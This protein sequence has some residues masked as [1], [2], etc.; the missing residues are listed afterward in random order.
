MFGLY[1]SQKTSVQICAICGRILIRFDQEV[2]PQKTGFGSQAR[3]FYPADGADS[4]RWPQITCL[5]CVSRRKYLWKSVESVGEF[6]FASIRK[7]ARRRQVWLAWLAIFLSR[8]WRRSTQMG[9]DNMF[10]LCISQKISVEIR[11]ICGRILIRFDQDVSPQ[12]TG[13]ARMARGFLSHRWRRFA[14][15]ATDGSQARRDFTDNMFGLYILQKISVEI[16]GI[17]GPICF[18]R[19]GRLVLLPQIS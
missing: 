9:T 11:G 10:G 2:S 6:S 1:I 3:G 14:Q 17:C 7:L 5:G 4:H 8:R 13:L 16:R 15:M 19:T 12:K 18:K